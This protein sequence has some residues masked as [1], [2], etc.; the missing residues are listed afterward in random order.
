MWLLVVLGLALAVVLAV[1]VRS[2]RGV[3]RRRRLKAVLGGLLAVSLM[4]A[5]GGAGVNRHFELY[6]SWLDLL[7]PDSADLVHVGSPDALAK[8]T[9]PVQT[10]P[11]IP[12]HG[13][14]LSLTIPATTSGLNVGGGYV[15]LPPQYRAEGFATATFPV[16]QALNGSPGDPVDW[17][18][19][20][21]A[22]TQLDAAITSGQMAP[23]IV[24]FAPTNTSLLRS[25]ECTDTADGL[26]DE[27]YLTTDVRSWVTDHFRTDGQRWTAIGYSTGA[28][29]ALSLSFRHPGLYARVVSLDGYGAAL[30]DRYARGLWKNN[31]D[32]LDHSPNWWV[33]NHPPTGIDVYLLHG[34][35]DREDSGDA[36]AV[37]RALVKNGWW[38]PRS[39]LVAEPHG[40]HTFPAWLQAFT[41]SLV[42]ALPGP[43]APMGP[44]QQEMPGAASPSPSPSPSAKPHLDR[45]PAARPSPHSTITARSSP[46]PSGRTTPQ[47]VSSAS[48]LPSPSPAAADAASPQ[49]SPSADPPAPL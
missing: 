40:R 5:L 13:T 33:A 35:N 28:Y 22:D 26:L 16:V 29:C 4:V 19:G 32:K 47:L 3:R 7:G 38:T 37:W 43:A 34:A 45:S 23:A 42:W 48:A 24:V 14:L 39:R 2:L 44:A 11:G 1:T 6:R 17:I 30:T 27:T 15:Y 36:L 25:L 10:G 12:T 49:A 46:T 21:K 41:P 31:Q 20:I 18:N 9:A 8:A